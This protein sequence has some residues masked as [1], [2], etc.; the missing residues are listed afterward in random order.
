MSV[1]EYW[2]NYYKGKRED[3]I[4]WKHNGQ[5]LFDFL[6]KKYDLPK[7][8]NVLDV[9]TGLGRK[10]AYLANNSYDVWVFDVT[11]EPF[12]KTQIKHPE[13]TFFVSSATELD[14]A[15]EIKNIKFDL[16]LDLLVSQ[17]M[18]L[19]EKQ[20]YLEQLNSHLN[21][22]S[23]YVLQ[24]FY[25]GENIPESKLPW[26]NNV[27]QSKSDIEKIYGE[28]FEIIGLTNMQRPKGAVANVVL[29]KK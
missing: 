18:S 23:Y 27:S 22:N 15:K 7:S 1:R 8:G 16:V 21:N 3:D 29:K 12:A 28:Y 4:P 13:V 24:T 20:D 9:G 5:K 2:E 10:A 19:E 17:F 14:K 25:K 26:V 11:Q 6:F